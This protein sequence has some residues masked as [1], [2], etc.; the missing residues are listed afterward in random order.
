VKIVF[1]M[2]DSSLT[3][4]KKITKRDAIGAIQNLMVTIPKEQID[5]L[6]TIAGRLYF[7]V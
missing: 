1:A 6:M 3:E 2:S 5:V 7:L 4:A